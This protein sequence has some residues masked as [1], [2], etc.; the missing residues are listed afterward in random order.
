[1]ADVL[2]E[3]LQEVAKNATSKPKASAEGMMIAYSSLV[4]M[5]VLPI[6]VGAFRSVK[7]LKQ[8]KDSGEKPETMSKKDAAMF[9]FI[10]S[11][12]LLGLYIFFKVFSKEYINLLVTVYFFGLGVIAL[13]HILS[14]AISKLVPK[15]FQSH[16]HLVYTRDAGTEKEE[17]LDF[18]FAT[19]DII[20]LGLCSIVGSVYLWN[21]HW[22]INNIFGLAF[23]VN[24]VELLH[25]NNIKIGCI[26]LGGLFIYDIFWVFATDVMVT[27]AKSFEA[28][29]KLVFPQD[30]LENWLSSNNFAM[31]GLGDIVIPGIFIALLLRFDLSLK[32]GQKLY[33]YSSFIAYFLG[34][35]L[36]IFIMSYF[37]HAQP[38]LLYLVP[39]CIGIPGLVAIAKGDV[40]ALLTYEDHPEEEASKEGTPDRKVES[41]MSEEKKKVK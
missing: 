10:A 1:M 25:L 9:P 22:I 31:L 13:T 35:I 36:T 23:A 12:A 33:F 19:S 27:V 30:I 38:A 5:A 14:P 24:G 18:S 17:L 6:F 21:K 3:T 41:T 11:G 2:N 29:I 32:R 26:L 16:H 40:K 28:P 37:K 8:Q 7:C 15:S 39:A 4:I 20:A 34:L